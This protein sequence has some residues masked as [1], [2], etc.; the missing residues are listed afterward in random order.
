MPPSKLRQSVRPHDAA[1]LVLI[2][3][4]RRGP[5]VLMGRRHAGHSFMPSVFVF[6][7]GRLDLADRQ[8]SG[9]AET[10]AAP[11]PGT[12]QATRRRLA[13][14]ARAALRETFEETGLLLGE[15]LPR[16]D[17]TAALQPSQPVWRA[18]AAAG[19]APGFAA[20]RLVAR[21]ITPRHSPRRFHSRFF[22]ADGAAAR[23]VLGGRLGGSGELD[24]L[25]WFPVA[26]VPRLPLPEEVT[27]LVLAE[28]LAHR[29]AAR[30]AR[31][32]SGPAR[33][34]ALF[35]WVGSGERSRHRADPR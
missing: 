17:R 24:D 14:F 31:H 30:H 7:G 10:L 27:E 26:E 15:P 35:R 4:G 11:P 28:A 34:V 23:V 12:D 33:Q 2:R 18:F 9:F 22:L 6:P 29:A 8:P 25:G 1:G 13:S 32:G 3:D 5:E 19:L 21:A 16:L 20:L